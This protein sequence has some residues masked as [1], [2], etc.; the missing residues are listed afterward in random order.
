MLFRSC[1]RSNTLCSWSDVII[2]ILVF[3]FVPQRYSIFLTIKMSQLPHLNRITT[4]HIRSFFVHL[5][6]RICVFLQNDGTTELKCIRQFSP[7][8]KRF[9]QQ[10]EALDLLIRSQVLLVFLN[11]CLDQAKD[12]LI[13]DKFFPATD[14]QP[15][16]FGI[17]FQ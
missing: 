6:D 16:F 8:R 4:P 12:F 5:F 14:S 9:G 3:K 1:S 2:K 11:M 13:S 10:G 7:H 17:L 15:L